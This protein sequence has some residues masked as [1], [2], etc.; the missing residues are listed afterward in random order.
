MFFYAIKVSNVSVTLGCLSVTTLF[1]S[2]IEPL[3]QKRKIS[4]VEVIIG[5]LII[6]GIYIIFRFETRY[7]EGIVF[8]LLAALFA[9]IFS[10]LNKQVSLKYDARVI[11]FYEMLSGFAA[12]TV[13]LLLS[14]DF[15]DIQFSMSIYDLIF[16]LLLGIVC[17]AWAF[18]ATI[19]IMQRLSAYQVVLAINLEPVYGIVLAWVIFG[20][21]EQM[22]AGFY[23]GAAIIIVSVFM[24]PVLKKVVYR[25]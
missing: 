11:S 18:T 12:I 9:S 8:S 4:L 3:V 1:T 17:T 20:Q 10:M 16:L 22:T 5:L 13:F 25:K 15:N 2:F 21:S 19:G 24:Y 6:L 23:A 7:F 14:R